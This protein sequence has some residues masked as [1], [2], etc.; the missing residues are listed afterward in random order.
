MTEIV[1]TRSQIE[2][3]SREELIKLVKLSDITDR[4]KELTDKFNNFSR[5]YKELKSDLVVTKKC[6]S[7]LHSRIVQLEK[8]AVSNAQYHRRETLELNPVP[9]DIH[10]NVLEDTICKALS[11]TDQEVVPEDIHACHRMS[12]RDRVIVKF[13][14][15]K[16]KHNVQI[17]QKKLNQKSLE[18]SRLKFSGKLFVSESMCFENHQLAYKCRKLKNLGKI[19]STWFYN[20]AVN[21][22][23]MENGRIHKIFH[24]I[25]IEKLLEIDNLDEFLNR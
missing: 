21:I 6:N 17:K 4:L 7:L 8:N 12:N 20:N 3:L 1:F 18:L 15:R 5:K 25:D 2:N 22:K 10:D 13:K 19:H 14:D 16:L 23:L 24:I 9:Q 11:L